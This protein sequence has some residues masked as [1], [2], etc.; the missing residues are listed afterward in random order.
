MITGSCLC[1]KVQFRITSPLGTAVYCHCIQC[2]KANG[3]A[4]ASGAALPAKNFELTAGGELIREY[5][6]SPGKFRA[7]CSNC[8]S[9][10]YSRRVADPETIRV[11]LGTLDGDPGRRPQAHIWV[12][13]KAPWFDITDSLPQYQGNGPRVEPAPRG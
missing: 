13:A 3:T 5:E 11:R 8:G 6:S 10:V 12:D 4:F 9:P 2:R 7:F 1:S